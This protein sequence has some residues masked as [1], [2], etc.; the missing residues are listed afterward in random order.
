[1]NDQRAS[2]IITT[3]F[4]LQM[5]GVIGHQFFYWVQEN[6]YGDPNFLKPINDLLHNQTSATSFFVIFNLTT[7]LIYGFLGFTKVIGCY[8][9]K[10]AVVGVFLMPILAG[11]IYSLY[12]YWQMNHPTY[13]DNHILDAQLGW[14]ACL[15]YLTTLLWANK[16]KSPISSADHAFVPTA[17]KHQTRLSR[18]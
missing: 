13:P 7:L 6:F 2:R 16:A 17:A 15:I 18:D 9:N 3:T 12:E 14:L 11:I 4:I 8:R 5:F 10:I 1:M